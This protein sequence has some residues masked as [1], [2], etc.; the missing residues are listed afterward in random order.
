M[1]MC[2]CCDGG[3]AVTER[4]GE[5]GKGSSRWIGGPSVALAHLP[6]QGRTGM[7]PP[8][9][10][11]RGGR[12][13]RSALAL[14]RGVESGSTGKVGKGSSRW[15]GGPSVA[16]AHLPLQGRT[17]MGPP[18]SLPR[19]G[20]HTRSALALVFSLSLCLSVSLSLCLSVSLSLSLSVSLPLSLSVSL[21][22]CLSVSLS[23][24]LAVSLSLC[25]SVSLS[26]CLS[27]SESLCL[28]VSLSLCLSVSPSLRLSVSLSLCLCLSVPPCLYLFV[29]LSSGKSTLLRNSRS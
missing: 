29:S 19:G 13:T 8:A 3:G 25:P 20:R 24:C 14:V 5:V 16:L 12:H 2:V 11:P 17:G 27:V 10:L 4:S 7:G 21:S 26:L 9:S 23:L 18:A 6:L 1:C 22:L 28:S 15:I